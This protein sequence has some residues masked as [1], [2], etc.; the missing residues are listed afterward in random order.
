VIYSDLI[1]NYIESKGIK[2][3][4]E[5]GN[6]L[7]LND[8]KTL[9]YIDASKEYKDKNR[10]NYGWFDLDRQTYLQII[11]EN[12]VP[13]FCVIYWKRMDDQS[14]TTF[15]LPKQAII[16]IFGSQQFPE[17]SN[18]QSRL[19]FF[20][21]QNNNEYSLDFGRGD[22][23]YLLNNY[24]NNW[25]QINDFQ[26]L[27]LLNQDTSNY[28]IFTVKDNKK[29][30]F[31]AE[32][33]LE[34][35]F[36]DKFWRLNKQTH[37]S[38]QL[39]ENDKIIFSYGAKN[40]LGSATL[41]SN[42]FSLDDNQKKIF[43]HGSKFFEASHGVKLKETQIWEN[44]KKV[45]EFLNILSFVKKKD[46]NNPKIF[47]PYFQGGVK[48]ISKE[49]Y[50]IILTGDNSTKALDF[51][52]LQTFL[53]DKMQMHS[54]YQPIMIRTLLENNGR[55]SKDIIIQK[56]SELN[57]LNESN[58][59]R[60]IPV[61]DV[62]EKHK[63]VTK[64][65]TDFILNINN[66]TK[67]QRDQLIALCNWKI[68]NIPI[69]LEELIKVFDK[70][71][72]LFGTDSF[73]QSRIEEN[74][75]KFINRF[76]MEKLVDIQLDEY[77]IGKPDPNTNNVNR[78]TFCYFLEFSTPYFGSVGGRSSNKFGIHYNKK[79]KQYFYNKEKYSSV[80]DAFNGIKEE[81]SKTINAGNSFHSDRNWKVLSDI[82]EKEGY[83][84]FRNIRS[85][86]LS[87]YFPDDFLNMHIPNLIDTI[88]KAFRISLNDI[89]GL[90]L[91]EERLI[92]LKNSHPIMKNWNNRQ[93]SYFVWKSIIKRQDLK[94]NDNLRVSNYNNQHPIREIDKELFNVITGK[95]IENIENY[96]L[97]ELS[98]D[99]LIKEHIF[100]GWMEMLKNKKQMILFG[101][102]GTGKTFVS[103][104]FAQYLISQSKGG[105]Y[106]L[107]QFHPSYSYED[108]VEGI[109]PKVVEKNIT[110]EIQPG[111]FKDL[112]EEAAKNPTKTYVLI[113]DE[114]NRG[115]TSRIF[116]ELI[117][118][119]EYRGKKI[120]LPY[121]KQ[122]FII[123]ENLIVIGTMN[124]TDRSI[125]FL[126]YAL[127]RRFYFYRL[128]PDSS[129]LQQW[130]KRNDSK[131]DTN[132]IVGLF[133][134]I[135]AK[136]KD[137]LD[138][139]FQI[140]HSYFMSAELSYTKLKIL[141][142]YTVKPILEEYFFNDK[143]KI[144]SCQEIYEIA[145][146]VLKQDNSNQILDN[147][148]TQQENMIPTTT[149]I[150]GELKPE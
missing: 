4:K 42:L 133:N 36:S 47:G 39:R 69:N 64:E 43:S 48:K 52:N 79:A 44:P 143:I 96:S 85:K 87:L 115:Q 72:E 97:T 7:R 53:L 18:K 35:R 8:S 131:L 49:E 148:N 113:I 38:E 128:D 68:L 55:A 141:W 145:L 5:K 41:D 33:I 127:R 3:I 135:N 27:N 6:W 50:N 91:K 29:E 31:T 21:R 32:K 73:D 104:K 62:L 132:I 12:E 138:I 123:P 86:I 102:P 118:G 24:F 9:L 61:Y 109:K 16:K 107:V 134:D 116:G 114:I 95:E 119:F 60:N 146:K 58:D 136:I 106:E 98:V 20:V 45:V 66:I 37:F 28:W 10:G 25:N 46:S 130:L 26:N 90:F 105:K 78:S 117:Y 147:E 74:Y 99:T 34:I 23:K 94:E 100:E 14:F 82:M 67:D 88:C 103:T 110:Y 84:I 129:I 2:T 80:E 51:K 150:L 56:I 83:E 125:A 139:E 112:C 59:F 92:S 15:I 81:L 124:S 89:D 149:N 11:N 142:E 63:I 122:Y 70:N 57:S 108:F 126:D 76:P 101:P 75:Q 40:F 22:Q 71:P 137:Y 93:F 1:K 54:N 140:G 30:K 13:C 19:I 144:K 77:V 121:S 65:N 17:Y 111:I 120:L